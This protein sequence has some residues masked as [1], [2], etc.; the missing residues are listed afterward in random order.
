MNLHNEMSMA[1]DETNYMPTY[2]LQPHVSHADTNTISTL[3]N[4]SERIQIRDDEY[5]AANASFQ[6][7]VLLSS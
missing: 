1:G 6:V 2:S 4:S 3:L 7:S 5:N